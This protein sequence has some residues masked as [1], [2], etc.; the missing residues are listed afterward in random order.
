MSLF[1]EKVELVREDGVRLP[2]IRYLPEVDQAATRHGAGVLVV[3][4]ERGLGADV[5]ERFVRP[6]AEIGF[7]VIATDLVHG[8]RTESDDDAGER[9]RSLD[10]AGAIDEIAAGLIR[11]RAAASGR[12]AVIGIDLAGAI[13]IEAATML[14][15]IDA[16]VQVGGPPPVPRA[17]LNRVRSDVQIHRA[18]HDGPFSPDAIASLSD[19]LQPSGAQLIV[20]DYPVQEG[21]MLRPRD[22]G[23]RH[24]ASIAWERTREFLTRVLAG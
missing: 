12:L 4:G 19:R 21:F 14:P 20:H 16:V 8:H 3:A 22:D 18:A 7:I 11:L 15:H 13:A 9:A 6:L 24:H 17:R 10:H 2:A 1:T 5:L 23:E